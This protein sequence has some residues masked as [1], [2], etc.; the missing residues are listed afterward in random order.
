MTGDTPRRAARDETLPPRRILVTGA[1]SGLGRAIA[2]R[3]A[4]D[5]HKVLM[6]DV[7]QLRALPLPDGD[8]TFRHLDVRDE[9]AWQSA[10]AWCRK[11]WGGLDVLV[12]NAGV[13]AAGR[14]EK[15]E[16]A[17]WDWVLDI[18]LKGTVLGCRTFTP[19]FKDQGHGHIINIASMAGLVNPPG[20]VSYNVSKA[21]VV[22]LSE[23]LRHELKPFDIATTV[24]CPAFVRT[25]I[26]ESLRSPDPALA[27]TAR[28]L[29]ENGSL[30]PEQVAERVAT[31]VETKPFL[32]LTHSEGRRALFAKRWL[33]WYLNYTF[34]KNWRKSLNRMST[35]ADAALTSAPP[36][37]EQ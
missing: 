33:P 2:T 18:N 8:V 10:M 35:E 21:A 31:A 22:S 12:N 13:A 30:T 28:R 19:L 17:D 36:T 5:G 15:I 37:S 7:N 1:A 25:N 29:I 26:A 27:E 3:F 34:A 9:P 4:A 20:M 23:T 24:V 11:T 32:V 16:L 6:T 14:I